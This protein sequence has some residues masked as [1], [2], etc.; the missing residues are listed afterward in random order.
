MYD[1]ARGEGHGQ[2]G[3]VRA[4]T[5]PARTKYMHQQAEYTASRYSQGS[6]HK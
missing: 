6:T 2:D 4:G 5:E 1:V 3:E